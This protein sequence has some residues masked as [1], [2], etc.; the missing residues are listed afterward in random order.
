MDKNLP[1]PS[2][3][4]GIFFFAEGKVI[5]DTVPVAKGEPYGKALQYGGHYEFW[6]SL[7]PKTLIKRKFK[8]R[9][10]DAYPRGRV[11]YFQDRQKYRIYADSCLTM[12]EMILISELFEL[13]GVNIEI[14]TD[15]HYKCSKCNPDF[16]D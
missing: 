4:V 1:S 13:T 15:E 10:Y 16:S 9:A 8:A 14:E 12:D 6:E 3:K 2:P 5:M 11:V 7:A